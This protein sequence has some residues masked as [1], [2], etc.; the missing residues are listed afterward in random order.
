MLPND[1]PEWAFVAVY[2]FASVFF[3]Y[4]L[5][6]AIVKR[7]IRKRMKY[8]EMTKPKAARGRDGRFKRAE[9]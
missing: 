4:F 3:V 8:L 7:E 6:V 1:P 9:S 5:V 2:G